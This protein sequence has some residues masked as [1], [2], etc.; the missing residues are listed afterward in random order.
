[1]NP[2]EEISIIKTVRSSGVDFNELTTKSKRRK[3]SL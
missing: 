2:V 3:M 1:M